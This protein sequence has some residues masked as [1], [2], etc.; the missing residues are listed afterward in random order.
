VGGKAA[1]VWAFNRVIPATIKD[2][3][4]VASGQCASLSHFKG[5]EHLRLIVR[6]M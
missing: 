1:N 5:I 6:N 3:L 2:S 4:T